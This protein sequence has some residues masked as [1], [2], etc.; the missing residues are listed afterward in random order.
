MDSM[1]VPNYEDTFHTITES[2]QTRGGPWHVTNMFA[3]SMMVWNQI[4]NEKKFFQRT[5]VSGETFKRCVD[6]AIKLNAEAWHTWWHKISPVRDIKRC[7]S[8]YAYESRD[9]HFVVIGVAKNIKGYMETGLILPCS[10][11]EGKEIVQQMNT[12]FGVDEDEAIRIVVS[13]L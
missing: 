11:E 12:I 10:I 3:E 1:V 4:T 2:A 7:F 5:L 6:E 13:S 9:G 8:Y